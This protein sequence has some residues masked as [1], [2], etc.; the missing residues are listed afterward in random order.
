MPISRRSLD[1]LSH[2]S[3]FVDDNKALMRRDKNAAV[4][5]LVKKY[6]EL[7]TSLQ[8]IHSV[9]RRRMTQ[10]QC[11]SVLESLRRMGVS[12]RELTELS[13]VNPKKLV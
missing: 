4:N 2:R 7:S 3:F 13:S 10:S 11:D 6:R 1:T 12:E 5:A 9:E 8:L